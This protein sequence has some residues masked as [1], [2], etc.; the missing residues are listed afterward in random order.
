ML[1]G[2]RA[3]LYALG[4]S[5]HDVVLPGEDDGAAAPLE[6]A[7]SLRRADQGWVLETIDYGQGHPLGTAATE[8]EARAMVLRYVSRPLP[9]VRDVT[10]DELDGYAAAVSMHYFDLRDR[11]R[12]AGTLVIDLPPLLPLDRLGALDGVQLYPIDT[13]FELRS[14]P[15]H[16]LQSPGGAH[17]FLTARPVRVAAE[18]TPP[19]F[20]RPGGGLR[21]SLQAPGVGIRDLVIAGAMDRIRVAG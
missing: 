8:D 9:P 18:I 13:P 2:L 15:P 4:F 6:G 3:E 10:P 11:V 19:W 20:G 16:A 7:L 17:R 14:L 21:F 1:P 5:L 12:D